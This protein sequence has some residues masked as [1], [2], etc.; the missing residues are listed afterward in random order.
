MNEARSV[1]TYLEMYDVPLR[2]KVLQKHKEYESN[3]DEY[4]VDLVPLDKSKSLPC[5]ELMVYTQWKATKGRPSSIFIR[6]RKTKHMHT[7]VVFWIFSIGLSHYAEIKGED[8]AQAV[9]NIDLTY[10]KDNDPGYF[11]DKRHFRFK[12]L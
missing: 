1:K 9:K 11:V 4:G 8:L 6:Q 5:I 3:A 2:R 12:R 7:G 10:L